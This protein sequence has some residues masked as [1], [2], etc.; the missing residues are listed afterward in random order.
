MQHWGL[1]LSLN[2]EGKTGQ[3]GAEESLNHSQLGIW[4]NL[5]EALVQAQRSK[6]QPSIV[7]IEHL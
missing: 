3:Q 5:T 4:I 2:Y 1:I 7:M 6:P